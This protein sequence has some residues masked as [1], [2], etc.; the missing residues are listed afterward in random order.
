MGGVCTFHYNLYVSV[1]KNTGSNVCT[2][3]AQLTLAFARVASLITIALHSDHKF[4]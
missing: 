4:Y 3:L 1:E 2:Y